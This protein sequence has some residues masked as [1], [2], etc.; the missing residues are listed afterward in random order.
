MLR[1]LGIAHDF[2]GIEVLSTGLGLMLQQ[3]KYILDIFT[4]ALLLPFGVIILVLLIY[5]Q[6]LSF[7]LILNMLKLIINSYE[8]R[9]RRKRFRFILCSLK[10]NLQMSLLNPFTLLHLLFFDSSFRSILHPR[11]D[12]A[13]YKMYIYI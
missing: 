8:T 7:M 2:L 1:D 3:H 9:F 12:E 11:F 6:I 4:S 10:I 13:Y 5:L